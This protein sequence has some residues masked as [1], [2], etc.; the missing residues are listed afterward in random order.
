MVKLIANYQHDPANLQPIYLA[1]TTA[2]SPSADSWKP[3]FRDTIRGHRVVWAKFSERGGVKMNLW[4]RDS[5]GERMVTTV[6][7]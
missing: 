4:V 1:V 3:A 7:L 6:T 2:R 5:T